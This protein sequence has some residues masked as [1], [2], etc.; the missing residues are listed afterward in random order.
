MFV[1][2]Q[3]QLLKLLRVQEGIKYGSLLDLGAGDG[4]V[5]AHLASLFEKVYVTEISAVMRNLLQKQSYQ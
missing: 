5:T 3:S 1:I 4:K 2:S